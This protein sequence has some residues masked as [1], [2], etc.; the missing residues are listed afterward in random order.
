[1]QEVQ[2]LQQVLDAEVDLND[3][4]PIELPPFEIGGTT[5]QLREAS[6]DLR[7]RF[8]NRR[9]AGATADANSGKITQSLTGLADLGPMLVA[10]CLWKQ[11]P[12]AKA[13]ANGDAPFDVVVTEQE[14]RKFPGRLGDKLF[15]KAKEISGIDRPTTVE[16]VD[17]QIAALQKT[18]EELCKS[19]DGGTENPNS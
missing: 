10:G 9:F 8:T 12:R 5:Y 2:T 14:F 7:T 11:N 17:R 6:E 15:A 13:S 16:E 18:R 1:M 4:A 19:R 3:L